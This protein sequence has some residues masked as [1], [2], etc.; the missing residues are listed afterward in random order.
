MTPNKEKRWNTNSK[1]TK[2]L[3][4]FFACDKLTPE[5]SNN[6]KYTTALYKQLDN[7]EF[8]CYKLTIIWE[9]V[10]EMAMEMLQRKEGQ[11]E[12]Q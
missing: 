12:F 2:Q 3:C 6:Y 11:G 9:R 4:T 7:K 1:V 10:R 5:K 8:Q